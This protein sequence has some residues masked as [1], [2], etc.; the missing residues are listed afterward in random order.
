MATGFGRG[1]RPSGPDA[2]EDVRDDLV[3]R[4]DAERLGDRLDVRADR[5]S[6]VLGPLADLFDRQPGATL[7]QAISLSPHRR[8]DPAQAEDVGDLRVEQVQLG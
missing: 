5:F 1:R 3:L 8:G 7:G 2:V 4:G 6:R